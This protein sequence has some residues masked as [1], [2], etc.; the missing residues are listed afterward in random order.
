MD[1]N[2]AVPAATAA[3]AAEHRPLV[4]K[5]SDKTFKLPTEK[6]TEDALKALPTSHSAHGADMEPGEEESAVELP[7]PMKPIQDPPTSTT[8][9]MQNGPA[10]TAVGSSAG[11]SGNVGG[12][13]VINVQPVSS[14]AAAMAG[15]SMTMQTVEQDLCKRVSLCRFRKCS[16]I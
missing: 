4:K 16:E 12:S 11:S 7:P 15:T 14:S 2:S 5:A 8:A 10:S 6:Q 9:M 1:K 13:G 3:V